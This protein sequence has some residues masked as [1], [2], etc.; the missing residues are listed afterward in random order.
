MSS[1]VSLSTMKSQVYSLTQKGHP[2]EPVLAVSGI[3]HTIKI[4]SPDSRA[5]ADAE[6]G[7]NISS[8]ANGSSGY[9]SLSNRRVTRREPEANRDNRYEGLSSRKRMHQSYQILSQNDVQR[10]GGMRDAYITVRDGGPFSRL[11]TV[12]M[13][14]VDWI[15]LF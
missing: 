8:S 2:Y 4:F 12:E 10:Q 13:D 9:S 7:L 3:D 1:R 14:F 5:Q 15:N 11:R 6:A